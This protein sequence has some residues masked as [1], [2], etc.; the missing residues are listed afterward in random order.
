MWGRLFSLP[1]R[2]TFQSGLGATGRPPQLADKKVCPTQ[3]GLQSRWQTSAFR[4]PPSRWLRAVKVLK[5]EGF[6][7]QA[8]TSPFP[9]PRVGRAEVIFF[10]CH[11]A[12]QGNP[13]LHGTYPQQQLSTLP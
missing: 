6:S 2:R 5:R 11:G 7:S 13:L 4:F 1:V 10:V 3:A 9:P 12:L 8:F